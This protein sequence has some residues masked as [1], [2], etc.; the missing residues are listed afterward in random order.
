MHSVVYNQYIIHLRGLSAHHHYTQNNNMTAAP[1]E[2]PL[3]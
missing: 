1:V 2:T 3:L